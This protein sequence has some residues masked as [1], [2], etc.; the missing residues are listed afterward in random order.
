MTEEQAMPAVDT[1]D[2]AQVLRDALA[3]VAKEKSVRETV[4]LNEFNALL[5]KHHCTVKLV[6]VLNES[7]RVEMEAFLKVPVHLN[8]TAL[9]MGVQQ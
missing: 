6:A 8:I 3:L 4:C 9:D 2:H 1:V 5:K 7:V